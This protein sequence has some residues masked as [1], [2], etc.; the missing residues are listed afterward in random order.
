MVITIPDILLGLFALVVLFIVIRRGHDISALSGLVQQINQQQVNAQI[1]LNQRLATQEQALSESLS[2]RFDHMTQRVGGSLERTSQVTQATL[3]QLRERLSVIDHAQQKMADLGQQVLSLKDIFSNKQARGAFGEIQLH[4][5]VTSILPPSA[6][7][8][9]AS[10]SNGKR[11]D[12]LLTLPNPP[13][14]I[15]IDAKFPL[16]SY[17]SYVSTAHAG[18]K[19]SAARQFKVDMVKHIDTIAEKYIIP[20]E[21]AESALMF[22]PSERI[23][24]DLHTEF[25]DIVDY[26]FKTRVYIVSP[27]TLM[28]TLNTMRSILKNAQL[29]E[30]AKLI[31]R[32]VG[33]F[34]KDMGLLQERLE[35]LET[36]FG[37]AQEDL[38][39]LRISGDKVIRR[40]EAI[41]AMEMQEVGVLPL[42]EVS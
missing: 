22:M 42:R 8:F 30:G 29:H 33:L 9:Q 15:A 1:Q 41:E 28:A 21:T 6:Y 13:G 19:I 23:Y 40:A 37:Q 31:Q 11:P 25:T 7:G 26:A 2:T 16:E 35:K 17:R 20:G 10:L 36:H 38:R 14:A 34:Q 12:C 32:E 39:L 18:D 27:T 4:D 24:A 3:T 5:L